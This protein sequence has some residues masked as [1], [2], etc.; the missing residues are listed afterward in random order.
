[1]HPT[2]SWG[3]R[4]DRYWGQLNTRRKDRWVFGDKQTGNY[5][6]KYQWFKIERHVLV[7]GSASPDDPALRTYFAE[8]TRKATQAVFNSR[9]GR[10]AARTRWVCMVCHQPLNR[11]HVEVHH[12]KPCS[13][14]GTDEL[15]NLV[16]VH[17][18]CH[19]QI[20]SGRHDNDS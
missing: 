6:V 9:L 18:F 7:K 4:R 11:E 14:G 10:I 1:M 2:K 5:L 3:W 15:S 13:Q 12:L 8:R 19:Q 20:H 16:L 17:M